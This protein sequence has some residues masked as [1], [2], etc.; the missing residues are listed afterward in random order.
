MFKIKING[1]IC[2]S[3]NDINP[4]N[5]THSQ[6]WVVHFFLGNLLNSKRKCTVVFLSDVFPPH[7]LKF[8]GWENICH[9]NIWL[10]R[11]LR[12]FHNTCE[13][14]RNGTHWDYT[15]LVRNA[16]HAHG[17]G[18]RCSRSAEWRYWLR[19][20]A[21][22]THYYRKFCLNG[23]LPPHEAS[24]P[25]PSTPGCFTGTLIDDARNVRSSWKSGK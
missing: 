18:D 10:E 9:L 15:R 19:L 6:L 17:L 5:R 23:W 13:S 4:F 2:Y 24:E 1:D 16:A 20:L 25:L 8:Q 7:P 12:P 3:W 21:W 14:L 11:G 22:G